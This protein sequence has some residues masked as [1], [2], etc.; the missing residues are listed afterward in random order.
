MVSTGMKGG[1]LVGRRV[2]GEKFDDDQGLNAHGD[3]DDTSRSSALEMDV[4]SW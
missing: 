4:V 1:V 2:V 3:E